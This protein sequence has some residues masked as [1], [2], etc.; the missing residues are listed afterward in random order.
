[1]QKDQR[2]QSCVFL[3]LLI[4]M[5]DGVSFCILQ[6]VHPHSSSGKDVLVAVLMFLAA[7]VAVTV[8]TQYI[9]GL[10]YL[11]GPSNTQLRFSVS[12]VSSLSVENRCVIFPSRIVNSSMCFT[13]FLR[14]LR[15]TPLSSSS[16]SSDD[17]EC[18]CRKQ[19]KL[20]PDVALDLRH[21][22]WLWNGMDK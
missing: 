13:S 8:G 3:E 1:M 15:E 6:Y 12:I 20:L 11:L 2:L 4:G 10:H 17:K 16:W 9:P 14:I 19:F 5:L 7:M 18:R 21:D 22:D